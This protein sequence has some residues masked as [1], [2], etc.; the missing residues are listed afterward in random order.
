MSVL[1][2]QARREGD[3]TGEGC[4]FH[5]PSLRPNSVRHQRSLNAGAETLVA[6]PTHGCTGGG[7]TSLEA[8]PCRPSALT[9][10][11]PWPS[12]P[13]SEGPAQAAPLAILT[14]APAPLWAAGRGRA[15][16][17]LALS[18][19]SSCARSGPGSAPAPQWPCSPITLMSAP[20]PLGFIGSQ[21][22]PPG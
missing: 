12:G 3:T 18:P 13:R 8:S 9:L 17:S 6:V 11:P 2:A 1:D 22:A 10:R 15:P 20:L 5:I 19:G 7:H 14:P 4:S 16:L 21:P